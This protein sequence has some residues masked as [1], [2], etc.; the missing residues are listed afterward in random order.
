[1]TIQYTYAHCKVNDKNHIL[2][3]DGGNKCKLP[4]LSAEVKVSTTSTTGCNHKLTV[5]D[6]SGNIISDNKVNSGYVL[7]GEDVKFNNLE[8]I[9]CFGKNTSSDSNNVTIDTSNPCN[10]S[11]TASNIKGVIK[12]GSQSINFNYGS[13]GV[14]FNGNKEVEITQSGEMTIQY[15]YA[16]YK[17]SDNEN[18]ILI[19]DKGNK[20]K[21]PNLS[22]EI[23]LSSLMLES[24]Q[25]F[26]DNTNNIGVSNYF[27][28]LNSKTLE[29]ID[30]VYT[31]NLTEM[32]PD[33]LRVNGN[34]VT[35]SPSL[36]SENAL[37]YTPPSGSIPTVT[38]LNLNII[39]S[40][41]K[42]EHYK[43][44]EYVYLKYTDGSTYTIKNTNAVKVSEPD[45]DP[46]DDDFN[47]GEYVF[48]TQV[49]L[50][51]NNNWQADLSDLPATDGHGNAYSYFIKEK[52][53]VG[54]G[55]D[56]FELIGYSHEE[57]IIL[58]NPENE[59]SLSNKKK[60]DDQLIIM[61]STGGKGINDYRN[62]GII[63]M[64]ASAGIYIALKILKKKSMEFK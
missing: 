21:L 33:K 39:N 50:D 3:Y 42:T 22:A 49:V 34:E 18:H 6:S 36:E 47:D 1:M 16:H 29:Y 10:E 55:A 5:K 25:Q 31:N 62:A 7:K 4:N 26:T 19:Y 13:D 51:K 23:M 43:D 35:I 61:P 44:I 37:R 2:I 53:V 27:N 40:S 20:C 58:Q 14:T 11:H 38:S 63:M 41:G 24:E 52:S 12:I 9:G 54:K 46:D 17:V 30:V 28:K 15:T 45:Y 48:V 56:L 59:T 60:D 57:G 32:P 8:S 64:T